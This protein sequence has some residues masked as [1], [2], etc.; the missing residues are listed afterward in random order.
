MATSNPRLRAA[1]RTAI[2]STVTIPLV[3]A[4]PQALAQDDEAIEEIVTTGSRI[5]RDPNL[6][7]A[8]PVQSIAGEDIQLSGQTD[9]L[10]NLF[11]IPY[12]V[13]QS[14]RLLSA[15]HGH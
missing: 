1:L 5:A 6:G 14:L 2:Y 9:H 8:V 11:Q 3:F 10:V 12:Q 15:K 13:C 4:A 7:A